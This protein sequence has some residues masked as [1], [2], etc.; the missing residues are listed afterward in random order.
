[1]TS[2]HNNSA[3]RQLPDDIQCMIRLFKEGR[4]AE[5]EQLARVVTRR[6]PDLALGWKVL[7]A[8]L[9]QQGSKRAA[10]NAFE[11]AVAL[12]PDD[13]EAYSN[14]GTTLRSCGRTAEAETCLRRAIELKP[15]FAGAHNNLAGT[16]QAMGRHDEAE[17][18]Y[19]QALTLEPDSAEYISIMVNASRNN[20]TLPAP[21]SSTA[22]PWR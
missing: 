18:A 11:R 19:R 12:Q 16:L 9:K 10:L 7:G 13:A 20:V 21:N 14:L 4:Y 17:A 2:H 5:G 3:P 15:G 6:S 1:M 8:C 22:G